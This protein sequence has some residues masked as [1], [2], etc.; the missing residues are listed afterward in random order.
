M[1]QLIIQALKSACGNR[2]IKFQ[3]IVQDEQLHIYA[4]HRQDYQPSYLILEANVRA[5]IASLA[6]DKITSFWLYGRPLNQVEPNWQVFSELTTQDNGTI[7]EDTDSNDT[8]IQTDIQTEDLAYLAAEIDAKID[9][10]I[11]IE[12]IGNF[13]LLTSGSTGDARLLIDQNQKNIPPE[14]VSSFFDAGS[15]A[16]EVSFSETASQVSTGDTGLL[17]NQGL[18]HGSPLKEAEIGASF[19]QKDNPGDS[20]EVA[21]I[22]SHNKLVQYCFISDHQ[23]LTEKAAAPS[24]EIMRLVKFFHYL[25]D[26][27]QQQLAPIVEGYLGDGLIKPG[28][29]PLPAIQNWLTKISALDDQEL[30]AFALWL[31]R[32]CFDPTVTLEE[33]KAIAV[34]NVAGMNLKD[35]NRATEYSFVPGKDDSSATP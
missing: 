29:E 19:A 33:F 31:S 11:G 22:S 15:L 23:L 13:D 12:G 35:A 30:S 16:D 25:A 26:A 17:Q 24:K 10:E 8:D 9:S 34:Q 32:Y 2:N 28:A 20:T 3:V 14:E 4:N 7:E 1:E 5:A 27:D 18:I 21:N 6:L